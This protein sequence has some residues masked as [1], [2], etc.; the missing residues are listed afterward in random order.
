MLLFYKFEKWGPKDS[1]DEL[2]TDRTKTLESPSD[3]K[4]I[5]PVHPQGNQ[6]WIL[7]GRTDAKAEAPRPWPP[8]AKSQLS[9]EKSLMLGKLEGRRRRGWQRMRWLD[10]I[11]DSMDMSLSR[12]QEMVKDG[13]AWRAA[14]YGAAESRTRMSGWTSRTKQ[15]L[16][17]LPS[18]PDVVSCLS[19][20][21]MI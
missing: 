4:E 3:S 12:L 21:A 17:L 9:L 8:D 16:G 5:T 15:S 18:S 2:A 13:E 14:V 10:G 1:C 20:T 11:T 7:T 19:A 6:P